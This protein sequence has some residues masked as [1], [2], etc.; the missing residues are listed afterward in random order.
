MKDIVY[1]IIISILGF[2]SIYALL[3]AW[4][5]KTQNAIIERRLIEKTDLIEHELSAIM[6]GAFG[7]SDYLEEVKRALKETAEKQIQLEQNDLG[8]LPYNQAVRMVGQGATVEDLVSS[9]GVSRAEAELIE[10]LHKKSPP[11]ITRRMEPEQ[12]LSPAQE[13]PAAD[14]K[15][16][17]TSPWAK[18][19][20]SKDN[21]SIEE[22][23]EKMEADSLTGTNVKPE[24]DQQEDEYSII[25]KAQKQSK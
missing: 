18:N 25:E 8:N 20:V 21:P 11:A 15:S 17:F 9:C 24:A 10:L 19:E 4:R 13:K 23:V 1:L 3:V 22:I 7:M 6:D 16:S 12:P 2:I 5:A 14:V